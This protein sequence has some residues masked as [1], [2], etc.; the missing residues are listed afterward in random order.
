MAITIEDI[1][2]IEQVFERVI[3]RKLQP[4]QEK[5]NLIIGKEKNDLRAKQA[6]LLSRDILT[7]TE[8]AKYELLGKKYT[9]KTV[10]KKLQQFVFS[11]DTSNCN[12][13]V[14]EAVINYRKSFKID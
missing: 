11:D 5:I 14:T 8:V 10:K 13:V 9:N 6:E 2:A 7:I 12:K 1:E 3:Q 4:L